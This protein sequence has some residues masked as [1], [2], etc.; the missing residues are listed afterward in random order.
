MSKASAHTEASQRRA[1]R[2]I[3]G[4]KTWREVA[5]KL[6]VS[7]GLL[8]RWRRRFGKKATKPTVIRD[9]SEQYHTTEFKRAAV[10][11]LLVDKVP[12]MTLAKRLKTTD[13][14]LR[15][16][17]R[18]FGTRRHHRCPCCRCFAIKVKRR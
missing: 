17:R 9:A 7:T 5:D 18:Q 2:A 4:G 11:M 13:T 3:E 8:A 12:M 15:A 1:V 6:G 10:R 14:T 16:W